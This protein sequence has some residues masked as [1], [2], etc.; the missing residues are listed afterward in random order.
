[1]SLCYS[2]NKKAITAITTNDG[3]ATR[4][5]SAVWGNVGGQKTKLWES[6]SYGGNYLLAAMKG[7][8]TRLALYKYEKSG[9]A[10]QKEYNNIAFGD[11]T[12][13]ITYKIYILPDEQ[14]FVARRYN[15]NSC[16][17]SGLFVFNKDMSISTIIKQIYSGN[18][19]YAQYVGQLFFIS[20]DLNYWFYIKNAYGNYTNTMAIEKLCENAEIGP[21]TFPS[22][23]TG[24]RYI[25]AYDMDNHFVCFLKKSNGNEC[26][27]MVQFPTVSAQFRVLSSIDLAT[28]Y[29]VN[30]ASPISISADRK[31]IS[32]NRGGI[33]KSDKP[34]EITNV[35]M[36]LKVTDL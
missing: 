13:S 14:H 32:V 20:G 36:L 6:S 25:K 19:E 1:M 35:F 17:S 12:S 31:Y 26:I 30:D 22:G 24:I 3:I 34:F 5:V 23:Y 9:F 4:K 18:S 27:A 21:I 7:G 10:I 16:Q 33:Y 29:K 8:S 28:D 2:A 15:N 11:E